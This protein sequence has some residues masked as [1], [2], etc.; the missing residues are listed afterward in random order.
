MID[1]SVNEK[2]KEAILIND[3]NEN[4]IEQ[5]ETDEKKESNS[6]DYTI[7]EKA[8]Y[9]LK[10]ISSIISSIIYIFGNFSIWL[11]GFTNIYLISFR[12]HYNKNIDFSYSYC[13]IPL[14]HLSFCLT[15]PLSGT[16][17]DKYGGRLTIVLSNS[18]SCMAF[19]I[20][21]YSRN[22]FFD[23]SLI[24]LIGFGIAIGYN[25]TI[26]NACSYFMNRKALVVGIINLIP[27]ILCLF[28]IFYVEIDILNYAGATPSIEETYYRKKIFM[29]YQK[30]IIFEIKLLLFTCLGSLL[31]YFQN[32]PKETLKFG[33]NE[34][35]KKDNNP[36]IDKIEKKKKKINKSLEIKIAIKDKRTIKLIIMIFLFFPTINFINNSMRM[37]LTLYFFYE[38]GY[39]IVASISFL[40]FAIIGDC[41]QFRILFV[42]LAALLSVVSFT[43]A[44]GDDIIYFVIGVVVSSFVFS[45]FIV[46]FDVHIMN[47]YGMQNYNHIWGLVRA[48]GGISEI[49]G[50]IFNFTLE[51]DN[52]VY[53]IIYGIIGFFNLFSL[54]L[55]LFETDDK[56]NY[57]N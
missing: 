55:G 33:F 26:K 56:F 20:M 15:A 25:I 14:L 49:F 28:L 8:I 48:S 30:L 21:Y 17:E 34:K 53:K 6:K 22:I 45:G 46:I 37:H 23:Y 5:M 24:L 42:F 13:F 11:L 32:N 47:V 31:L 9:I 12:R 38:L 4:N 1:N 7:K 51:S 18:I 40:L 41:I 19:Y 43:I 27:N 36:N 16:I 44:F 29:N 3:K 57:N 35:I 10:G 2:E 39:N 54:F 52:S 50:I